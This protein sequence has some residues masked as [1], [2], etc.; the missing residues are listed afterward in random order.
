MK[1]ALRAGLT[2]RCGERSLELV[3]VL[4]DGVVQL[5]EVLTRRIQNM[6]EA[7]LVRRIWSGRM[8][9]IIDPASADPNQAAG[10]LRSAE[11]L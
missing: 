2:L 5:E 10:R 9:V 11:I 1:F 8:Q 4:P 3:R 6:R 7:E